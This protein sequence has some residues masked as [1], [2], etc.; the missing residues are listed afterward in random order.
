MPDSPLASEVRDIVH[1]EFKQSGFRNRRSNF[2]NIRGEYVAFSSLQKSAWGESFY[3]D[4]GYLLEQPFPKEDKLIIARCN[5]RTRANY[6]AT[7]HDD[8]YIDRLLDTTKPLGDLDRTAALQAFL[9]CYVFPALAAGPSIDDLRSQLKSSF[10]PGCL[11]MDR[12]AQSIIGSLEDS[13]TS[14]ER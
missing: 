7:P 3:L 4:I 6:L 10:G 12:Y 1:Q 8:R 14:E 13:T 11:M 9:R 2:F 5:I